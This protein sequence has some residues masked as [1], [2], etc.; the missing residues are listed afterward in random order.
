MLRRH[1]RKG[2]GGEAVVD[3]SMPH[4]RRPKPKHTTTATSSDLDQ[5]Y[6]DTHGALADPSVS[7]PEPSPSSPLPPPC[8]DFQGHLTA[9]TLAVSPTDSGQDRSVVLLQYPTPSPQDDHTQALLGESTIHTR[10]GSANK[11]P[12]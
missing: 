8:G 9:S 1:K 7:S 3:D 2:T 6:L 4:P 5:R 10:S 11:H 12:P